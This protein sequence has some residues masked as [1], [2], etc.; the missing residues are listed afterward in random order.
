MIGMLFLLL[1]GMVALGGALSHLY[2]GNNI[3]SIPYF[4]LAI[5]LILLAIA[6]KKGS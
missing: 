3:A 1:L 2:A 6:V 4:L 5:V